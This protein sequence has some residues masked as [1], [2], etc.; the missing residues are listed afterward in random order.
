MKTFAERF[1]AAKS[2]IAAYRY[3]PLAFYREIL[4]FEPH[5]GRNDVP[6]EGQE[7][8]LLGATK[9]ENLLVTGNRWGKSTSAAARAI[10]KCAYQIGWT[11]ATYEAMARKNES[12]Q[13]VNIAPT[14]DQA[15]IVFNKARGMLQGPRACWLVRDV[16]MTPFPTIVFCNGSVFQARSTAGDGAHLLGHSFDAINWD[17]AAL[18][19]HFQKILDNV[20]RMRLAD[21]GGTLDFTST[22]Q[23]RNSFGLYFLDARAGKFDAFTWIGS[24]FDNTTIAAEDFEN[25]ARGMSERL[26]AQN[27]DGAIIDGC[28]SFFAIE[29]IEAVED[30]NLNEHAVFERDPEDDTQ[31]ARLEVSVEPGVSWIAKYPDHWYMHGWDLAD[32]KDRTVGFTADLSTTP[33]TIVEFEAFRRRGWDHVYDRI[34]RRQAKYRTPKSTKIDST[35]LGDVVENELKDLKVEGFNFGGAGK[36]D[37]LLANLQTAFSLRDF[38][39]PLIQRVHNE[40]AFYE[41]DDGDLETDCVMGLGVLMWFAKHAKKKFVYAKAI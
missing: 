8:W 3:D 14:A 34:R 33:W 27:L 20:L 15:Q 39:M 32:K 23:G 35:G 41:R 19:P 13:Y 28:G 1:S 18:E 7:G 22:G 9:R 2:A 6:G 31:I 37:A 10:R 5:R 21:R 25:A 24:S 17:E 40:H 29:D 38:R 4:R 11:S 30:V 26:R 36:K 12:Y 16:K